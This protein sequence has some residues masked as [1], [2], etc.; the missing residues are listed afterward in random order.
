[1]LVCYISGVQF[2][3]FDLELFLFLDGR[4]GCEWEQGLRLKMNA[5][6]I[7][8]ARLYLR[9]SYWILYITR[10]NS[11]LANS[12]EITPTRHFSHWERIAVGLT[13]FSGWAHLQAQ[14]SFGKFMKTSLEKVQGSETTGAQFVHGIN[15]ASTWFVKSSKVKSNSKSCVSKIYLEL[16]VK[17]I[18]A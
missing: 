16:W 13:H 15:Q 12:K 5:T 2:Y 3:H 8:M 10:I 6:I 18:G 17:T 14:L 1:M 9:I 7:P 4:W 11:G